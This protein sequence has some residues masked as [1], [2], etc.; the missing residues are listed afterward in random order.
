MLHGRSL[1]QIGD[2]LESMGSLK[3]AEKLY[4]LALEVRELQTFRNSMPSDATRCT[5]MQSISFRCKSFVDNMLRRSLVTVISWWNV[6]D[7]F[8]I[9]GR[10]YEGTNFLLKAIR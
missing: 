10:P 2:M 9:V 7:H 5:S 6:K 8:V 3:S 4:R 1:V